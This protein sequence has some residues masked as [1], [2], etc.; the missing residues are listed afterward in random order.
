MA[1]VNPKLIEMLVC[2]V[3]KKTLTLKGDEL[4]SPSAKLAYPI[5]NGIP[6][7]LPDE[8]RLIDDPCPPH[9]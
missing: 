1:T 5:R 8:A 6:I 4:I 2:P 7:M 3:T 9:P